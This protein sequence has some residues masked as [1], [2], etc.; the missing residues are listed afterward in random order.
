[1]NPDERTASPEQSDDRT[2]SQRPLWR[3]GSGKGEQTSAP[4][5]VRITFSADDQAGAKKLVESSAGESQKSERMIALA[6]ERLPDLTPEQQKV[7]VAYLRK[8]ERAV[9][10]AVLGRKELVVPLTESP[11]SPTS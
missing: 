9:R 3:Q 6:T 10:K 2:L 11:R 8:N 5:E 7:A 1:M 4:T